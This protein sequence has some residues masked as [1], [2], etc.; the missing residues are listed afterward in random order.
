MNAVRELV[1][2]LRYT[3]DQS[4]LRK[5]QSAYQA[6]LARLRTG[7][8]NIRDFG[9]GFAEGVRDGFREV[10]AE[11][12]ALNAAQSQGV[13]SVQQMG[14]G[15]RS[16]AGVV[17]GLVAG[18]SIISAARI[19]DEWSSVAGRVGL[20]T[21]S[22]EDQKTALTEIYAIAQRAR[23]EYTATGDLFQK[24]QRNAKDLGLE[25]RDSLGLT[26]VIA[27]TMTIGG[28]DTGAQQAALMQL[29][30]A[31]GSG[32]LRGDELNSIIE[33][34]PRLAE[35]I[36][37]SFGVSVGELRDLGKAGKLTS[38]QLAEGLLKQADKINAEFERMPKTFGGAMVVLRNALGREIDRF[39]RL[40]GAANKFAGAATWV[41]EHMADVLKVMGL[42][43]ASAAIV[44]LTRA[45]R[46]STLMASGLRA[47]LLRV[48]TAAWASLGPY[49]AV[50][51]ALG[52]I[53]L[54][55][56]DI[57]G[58]LNGYDS[59]LGSVVGNVEEWGGAIN[60]IV[61]PLRVIGEALA[62]IGS[63]IGTMVTAFANWLAQA[64]GVGAIFE[65]WRDV[66]KAVFA[67][68]LAFIGGALSTVASMVSAVAAAF[69]GDWDAALFHVKEAFSK[70]FETIKAAIGNLMPD[71][72]KNGASWVGRNV[73]GVGG[74]DVQRAGASGAAVTV[75]NNIAGVTVNAPNANPASVA[76]ATNQ[77]VSRALSSARPAAAAAV[78]MV[79]AMP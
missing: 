18:V 38:K 76:A 55:G 59:V 39:N 61:A 68:I 23:Q 78:P 71:W 26:E 54:I 15:Y 69:R 7:A 30:Q 22:V 9:A 47:M 14:A 17:R 75:Q 34:A 4:G 67:G 52:A 21:S 49:L 46:S 6:A 19:A 27:K 70:W 45:L 5:Y 66:V 51:A 28:G 73:M 72:L 25:L 42:I 50:A 37:E 31:L 29:G 3:V 57:Y 1:T 48:A 41:A 16:I 12:R 44:S 58:W 33:Q 53:Y 35:A 8:R 79:E 63:S 65:N 20:A 2:V 74:A 56:Q 24:V 10:V 77:G 13:A 32:S 43:G 40:T 62:S 36:A 11:Q 64:V 60:G